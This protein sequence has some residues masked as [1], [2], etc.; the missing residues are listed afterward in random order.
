MSTYTFITDFQGGTYIC[1]KEAA[2]LR[3]ACSLWQED[4]ASGGYVPNL[5]V[6]TFAKAFQS[7]IDEFPPVA[8]DTLQNVWLFHLTIGDEQMDVHV[9]QTDTVVVGEE[10]MAA[11]S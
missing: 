8:L 6:K 5:K 10:V 4:L 3:T 11:G 1:Q 9:I 7:D 2:T